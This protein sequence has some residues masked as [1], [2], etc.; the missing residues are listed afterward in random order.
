[1]PRQALPIWFFI[2]ALLV[3]YG[4]LIMGSGMYELF[5]PPEHPP[6]LAELRASIWWGAL[7]LVIGGIYLGRYSPW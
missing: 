7:L 4:F 5:V 6:V 2:G 3:V 1:M